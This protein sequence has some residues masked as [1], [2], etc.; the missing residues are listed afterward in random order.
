MVERLKRYVDALRLFTPDDNLLIGV[1]GGIDSIVLADLLYL[2]GY[3][4]SIAHCNFN[5]RGAESDRDEAF[6]RA[7]AAKYDKPFFRHSFDTSE[8]ATQN[9]ISIE[10]AARDL[11]YAW[12]EEIRHA[13]HFDKIVV[14]H[15]LDD[16]AETF[17]LNL[18]RGTG[19]SGLTGIK[20]I[21][22]NVVRPLL[23]ATR[24]EIESYA[25][26]NQLEYREDS[27]NLLTDFQRNKI[28]H[29]V[30]PLMEELNP[31]F[32]QG[33]Q[34][35]IG[36]LRDTLQ[37]YDQAVESVK[38]RVVRRKSHGEIEL[39]IQ[40]LKLL[41]PLSSYLFEI[42]KPYHFNGDV[43]DEMIKSIG[44]QSG[45]QF[46]SATHRA[47]LDR[48]VILIHELKEHS[49][50]RYY[51]DE[52]TTEID[53]PVSLTITAQ[54][55]TGSVKISRSSKIAMVDREKIQFPL[56]LRKWQKG[57][58]FQPLGMTGMK[59][60]SDFFVDEKFSLP[61]KE[62]LWLL[63]NGE[64]IVWILGIRLDDRYKIT[65]ETNKML[66]FEVG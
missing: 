10:M 3:A 34:E 66:V 27:T 62:N 37:V 1:S 16:Q 35:T 5:L 40:E 60:L 63:T 23:F 38:E 41:N 54:E 64:E 17:F 45:K 53:F 51:L 57:D 6:V 65:S 55:M 18:A 29:L 59:K 25:S 13:H 39:S 20:A 15:H 52:S 33:L 28:R 30:L 11:R 42:L 9:G 43:V 47:V 61:E 4:F 44:G 32:R 19:I 12:F 49:D 46:Y 21:N 14:A 8:Y 26:V 58:Y 50:K 2:A 56:I 31:S 22:G 36:Y 7:L 24:K 48:E